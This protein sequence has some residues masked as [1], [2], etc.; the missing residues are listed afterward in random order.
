MRNWH[1]W[2]EIV[3][4][5]AQENDPAKLKLLAAELEQALDRRD[6]ALR[7][8]HKKSDPAIRWS[9]VQENSALVGAL[10]KRAVE[11]LTIE[12]ELGLSLGEIAMRRYEGAEKHR[13]AASARRAYETVQR[14]IGQTQLS[15]GEARKLESGL[16]NLGHILQ[17]LATR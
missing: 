2:R 10:R 12:I 8:F 13:A 6:Q 15:P 1:D 16:K 3:G 7:I 9:L 14:L 5:V 4:D 17:H 11:F